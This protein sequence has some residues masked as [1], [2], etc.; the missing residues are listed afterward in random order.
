MDT[1]ADN[2]G[3][4]KVDLFTANDIRRMIDVEF[5][6]ELAIAILHGPQ[7]KKDSLEEWYQTYEE[8]F[9]QRADVEKAFARTLEL[10]DE[11]LPT[12]S[13]LRWTKKSDFYTLFCVLNKLPSAGSLSAAAK[14]SLGKAL[15]EFAAEVDAVLDGALPTSEEVAL[16]VHGVQRAASD[17]G[18]RR[19]REENL[20]DYL[21]AH[22][23]WT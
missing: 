19:K 5:V 1:I 10:V 4:S 6:S 20:I 8:S 22:Q 15:R 9:P 11:I 2:P 12:A 14:E 23:L 7:N 21:K 17:R 18:N 13:G 3:W 16:Y